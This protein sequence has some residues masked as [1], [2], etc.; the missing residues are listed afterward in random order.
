[1]KTEHFRQ[2]LSL[3]RFLAVILITNSHIGPL[4]PPHLQFLSTGGA[5]GNSLFFFCSGFALYLSNR[6]TGFAPW[7]IRR[8]TRIYPSLWIFMTVCFLGGIQSFRLPDIIIPTF[9]FLQAIFVFYVFFFYSIKFFERQLWKVCA[10]FIFPLLVTYFYGLSKTPN[11]TTFYIGIFITS[12]C[13]LEPSP[14]NGGQIQKALLPSPDR[15]RLS[16]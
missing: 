8:F 5:L 16:Y 14:P 7:A 3:M 10:A 2:P 9:W 15:C 1:M 6:D 11:T 4:Y 13:C 12:L